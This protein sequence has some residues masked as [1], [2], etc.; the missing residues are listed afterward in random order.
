M[1]SNPAGRECGPKGPVDSPFVIVGEAPGKDEI[2]NG[3][4]FVGPSGEV[5]NYALGAKFRTVQASDIKTHKDQVLTDKNDLIFPG[6]YPEPY[7]TNTQRTLVLG[8]KSPAYLT[9]LA[10]AARPRLVEEIKQYPRKIILALGAVAAQALLDKPGL[11]ITQNRGILFPSELA[12]VGVLAA[13]HPAYLL[14][15][16]GSFRQF[17]SDVA[18][19][20][21]LAQGKPP[22]TWEVP[23]FSY[24]QNL[25][26]LQ[27]H[28]DI[29]R[30]LPAGTFVAF[31]KETED[32]QP[33]QGRILNLG[34][35]WDGK[36]IYILN[37]YKQDAI[38]AGIWNGIDHA[39]ILFAAC[40]EARL[41]QVWHNGK[42]DTRWAHHY[43]MPH[44][45]VDDDTMLM[46]YALDEQRGIHDLETVASDWVASPDWKGVLD[47][48]KKKKQS[49]QVIPYAILFKY[50]AFDIA[51]T[52]RV[53]PILWTQIEADPVALKQY[54]K[55]LIPASHYLLDIEKH[56]IH[57]DQDR[58]QH[59]RGWYQEQMQPYVDKMRAIATELGQTK[60]N[61]PNYYTEKFINSWQQLGEI[62]FDDLGLRPA[63]GPFVR[64]TDQDVLEK[65]PKH[66]F[67]DALR[68]YR[69]LQ[70]GY[71]TYVKPLTE[72]PED[73][74][75]QPDGR[76][77]A[78]YLIHG[79]ATGRLSSRNPNLQNIPR[80]PVLRGQYIAPPGRMLIEPDLNQAEIRSLAVLSG[81][82]ELCAIY[83]EGKVG[84]HDKVRVD[85]FGEPSSWTPP[86]L[87]RYMDKWF[88]TEETRYDKETK[89]DRLVSEMKM[90]A[91]NVNFGIIYGI[92][93]VGLAEQIDDTPQ[94]AQRMLDVWA[95]AFPVAWRFIQMC[96]Q[97]PLYHKNLVTVFGYRKRFQIIT[98]QNAMMIQNEAAN[99]PHQN[100]AS[101]ITMQAGIRT[102]ERLRE[103]DAFY[104]N[105]VHDS[106]IIEAPLDYGIAKTI[107]EMVTSE[108]QQVPKDWGLTQ[109][110]FV[111]DAKWGTRWGSLGKPEKFAKQQG[112][113]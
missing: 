46:S 83:R 77:H 47:Q 16:N 53:A 85:I 3:I 19:A 64:S 107:T 37:G 113:I 15:G 14:R 17:K 99:F 79:T 30:G 59:N 62:L 13:V 9:E 48:Y 98:P 12:E 96:R 75:I 56:G 4:P 18:Y 91:K 104:V 10:M 112:W 55:S 27:H 88:L 93:N 22:H 5:L 31:D 82:P 90:R 34:Y 11:K 44:A 60:H 52:W 95:A 76:V 86:E 92:T 103:Y 97:A 29:L 74:V 101:V 73:G 87:Q 40:K 84:L 63:S 7:F 105:T 35:T 33:Q 109:I 2:I 41:R 111:A 38:A 20:I 68:Q 50:A 25:E 102:Y 49:Y 21:A 72:D 81:D 6:T 39:D 69:K 61:D 78:T 80:D 43:N 106:L 110:P 58:V 70:K 57:V 71:S 1:S 8:E 28:A 100:T 108:M 67:L 94:E 36:H 26:E 54:A 32:F 45:Y 89:E 23:T 65:L 51:N 42:F 66:P 24:V